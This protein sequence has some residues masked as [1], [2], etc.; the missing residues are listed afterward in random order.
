MRIAVFGLGYVGCVTGACLSKMGHEVTGVDVSS[1]KVAMI[2]AGES[3]V[4]EKGLAPMIARAVKGKCLRATLDAPMAI[5]RSDLSL[6][7]V[8]TPARKDGAV[9][10]DFV[11]RASREIGAALR[12]RGHFHTIVFRSTVPPG[13]T[14][15]ILIP[16]LERASRKKAGRD[17]GVCFHPEFLREGNS[18]QDFL[19]PPKTVIGAREA[20]SA[21]APA[22]LWRLIKA[23]MY[24][25]S[26]RVAEMS[27]YADNTFHA[28]KVCFANEIGV[29][30]K[31]VSADSREVMEIFSSDTKLN[32]SR[33][34]LSPGF[35][36]GG[37]CLPKDVRALAC[38]AWF[39]SRIRTTCEGAPHARWSRNCCERGER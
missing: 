20:K 16:E 6:V 36:F 3:P 17:F 35:A 27:K 12:S 15:E 38:S 34:Y 28:L 14:E 5:A 4:L 13:T 19:R 33:L 10:L 18:V 8:G 26:I 25:C 24:L 29:L 39:L 1:Q 7:C 2:Q 37:P 31:S 11:I 21:R 22:E 9:N 30:A 32:I 23:P